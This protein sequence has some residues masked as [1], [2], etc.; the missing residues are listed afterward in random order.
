ML[1]TGN[2]EPLS[3][4]IHLLGNLLGAVIREQAGNDAFALEERV[5]ELAKSAR[6]DNG[7]I[8]ADA[9]ELTRVITAAEL[10]QLHILIKA[11]TTYFGLVNLAEQHER[12]RVLREREHTHPPVAESLAEAIAKL[13]ADGMSA[14]QLQA[15]L[16]QTVVK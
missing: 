1:K 12:L 11:F 14:E 16:D 8:Q 10:P 9:H 6:G 15:Q 13:K 7:H 5:R 3:E 2:R 4:T